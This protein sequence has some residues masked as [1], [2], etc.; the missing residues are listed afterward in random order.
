[1]T[2]LRPPGSAR[3][4]IPLLLALALAFG[5][6][7]IPTSA[8]AGAG[9]PAPAL[10]PPPP[11]Q[12]SEPVDLD[13]ADFVAT[14]DHPYWPMTPGTKWV[15]REFE[16][17]GALQKV[18]VTVTHKT[19]D[20][21]GIQATVV[22]DLVTEKGETIEDTIDWYAQDT[23]GNLWYLGENTKEYENGKVVSTEG[24]WEHGVD[25]AQ[26]GVVLPA[27]PQVG[28][29]YR[30][31]YYAGEAEDKGKILSLDELAQVPL[32]FYK[33]VLMTKDFTPLH[34]RIL[35]HKFYAPGVGPVLVVAIS[36]GAGREELVKFHSS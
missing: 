20:I 24:S 31:E 10:T 27:D 33:D 11:P 35:E 5:A 3:T 25:G 9:L 28:M 22:H 13:P 30:Q 18:V 32:G 8:G 23:D 1:M 15:Y 19:K 29:E 21:Q 36:G 7:A 4:T 16:R 2:R 17:G 14:I 34:P 6:I 26:A 12:G